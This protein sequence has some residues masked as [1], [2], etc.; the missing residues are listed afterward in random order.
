MRVDVNS[1]CFS[2]MWVSGQLYAKETSPDTYWIEG[3]VSS[4][5]GLDKVGK[6]YI[7]LF[8]GNQTPT[9]E[10]ISSHYTTD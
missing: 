3:W 5:A 1:T 8:V 9:V 7:P 2:Q 6:T 4:I 10:F